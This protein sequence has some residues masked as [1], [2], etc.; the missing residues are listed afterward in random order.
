MSPNTARGIART[1]VT[2]FMLGSLYLSFTHIAHLFEAL[3]LV[4]GEQWLAPAFI[5]TYMVLGKL[6]GL[7]CWTPKTRKIGH[8]VVM[9]GAALSIIANV[10]A[11]GSI[12]GRILGFLVVAGFLTGEWLLTVMVPTTT[13]TAKPAAA[14]APAPAAKKAKPA[15]KKCAAG[16]TCGKHRR[17]AKP[18]AE[19]A[20]ITAG[21]Y[22]VE[23][24]VSGA[25]TGY[26]PQL[27]VA[28]SVRE[29]LNH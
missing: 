5:D 23:A 13:R 7:K 4:T 6:L 21:T 28:T 3:G 8:Y 17:T 1:L 10:A 24:P 15:A 27:I 9:I 20:Q 14:P 26:A 11:G 12:G 29:H 19:L 25:A 18:E 22:P 2:A 16:C